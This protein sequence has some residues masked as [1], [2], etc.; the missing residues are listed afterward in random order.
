MENLGPHPAAETHELPQGEEVLARVD[1]PPNVRQRHVAGACSFGGG[2]QRA[3]AVSRHDDVV[4]RRQGWEQTGD[5]P[6]SAARLG[7]RDDEEDTR[8][9]SHISWIPPH[10]RVKAWQR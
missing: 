2:A 10:G 3:G 5:R 7:E 8:P 6:L 1:V 4:G 9:Q